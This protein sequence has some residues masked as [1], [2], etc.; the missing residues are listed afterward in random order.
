MQSLAYWVWSIII[1]RM[2][3]SFIIYAVV[4]LLVLGLLVTV[5]DHPVNLSVYYLLAYWVCKVLSQLDMVSNHSKNSVNSCAD[6]GL[7]DTVYNHPRDA[8]PLHCLRSHQFIGYV[9]N[10]LRDGFLS[11]GMYSYW[12]IGYGLQSFKE[13][14][15][16]FIA[17]I[18]ASSLD[19]VNNLSKDGTAL[20]Y[21]SSYRQSIRSGLQSS[22]GC[23]F[24]CTAPTVVSLLDR[25]YNHLR[26]VFWRFRYCNHPPTEY[27]PQLSK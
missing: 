6:G 16:S 25:I 22:K 18:V 23:V 14:V 20:L 3:F 15:Y 8:L 1:Q 17:S 9:Y 4:G 2:R 21:H 27:G 13:C 12:P 10:Y 5:Y 26:D 7:S 24:C 19:M 11:F